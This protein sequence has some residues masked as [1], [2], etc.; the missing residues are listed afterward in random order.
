MFEGIR[1]AVLTFVCHVVKAAAGNSVD[2]VGFGKF[3]TQS[4]QRSVI[5]WNLLRENLLL[6]RFSKSGRHCC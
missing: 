4:R 2:L 1:S 6:I 3:G 5:G